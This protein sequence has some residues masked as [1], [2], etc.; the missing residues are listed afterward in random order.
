MQ[1]NIGKMGLYMVNGSAG[2][3]GVPGA[4]IL[5]FTLLVNA[6][7]GDVTGHAT[8]VQAVEAPENEIKIGDITGK[9]QATGFGDYTKVVALKGTG[10]VTLPP[11]AIGSYAVP[12]TAHFAI[13]DKWEGRGGWSLGA[14]KVEDVPVHPEQ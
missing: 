13:N 12:F 11:P 1:E 5:N 4:P 7:T 6:V 10:I 8:Q 3:E 9:V 2:N 14:E